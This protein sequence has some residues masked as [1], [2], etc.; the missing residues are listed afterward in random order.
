MVGDPHSKFPVRPPPPSPSLPP[1]KPTPVSV[2]PAAWSNPPNDATPAPEDESASPAPA[3]PSPLW[4]GRIQPSDEVGRGAVGSVLRGMDTKLRRELAIKVTSRSREELPTPLVA[5]FV[6]E[7]QIT[8]QLEH[9]NVIP[10]HDLG[11]DPEGR[12][13][14]TMKLVRGRSFETILEQRRAR[15]PATLT[16]FGLR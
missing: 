10:V 2:R 15:D 9:A 1:A 11:L 4:G 16:E 12:P 14:F 8:A 5:R 3:T 6:E 7:A 13:Y